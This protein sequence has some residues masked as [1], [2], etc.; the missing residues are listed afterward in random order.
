MTFFFLAQ[1]T[2]FQ[3]SIARGTAYDA[4][5]TLVCAPPSRKTHAPLT[6]DPRSKSQRWTKALKQNEGL[7]RAR[8]FRGR[9]LGQGRG[10]TATVIDGFLN[11]APSMQPFSKPSMSN[12][13]RSNARQ[14]GYWERLTVPNHEMRHGCRPTAQNK[15][16]ENECGSK[17]W[18]RL[19]SLLR[20]GN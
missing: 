12:C 9:G 17:G 2:D 14:F 13:S 18:L 16:G 11:A 1:V 3:E 4:M 8:C 6:R 19:I 10:L 5:L 7:H 20:T 15:Q